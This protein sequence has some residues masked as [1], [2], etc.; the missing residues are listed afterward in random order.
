MTTTWTKLKN[1]T[2]GVRSTEALLEGMFV[3]VSRKDG[4][5]KEVI[6]GRQVWCG[7]GV[8]VYEVPP[9]PVGASP[10]EL[11]HRRQVAEMLT[12]DYLQ[13]RICEEQE[14]KRQLEVSKMTKDEEAEAE[15]RAQGD[16]YEVERAYWNDQRF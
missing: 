2:W 10:R 1:G 15:R 14:K 12:M 6:I 8:W 7:N 16:D 11:W 5:S 4:T 3:D 9:K 13:G